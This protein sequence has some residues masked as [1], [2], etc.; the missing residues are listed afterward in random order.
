MAAYNA[1]LYILQSVQSVLAQTFEDFELL[2]INDG[3]TDRTLDILSGIAD[4]RLRILNNPTNLGVVGSRNRGMA[5]AVGRYVA[6][7]DADDFCLPTRFAKQKAFL[8]QHPET[9]IVGAEMSVLKRGEIG[10][11]PADRGRRSARAA[12][13][14]AY[15]QPRRSTFQ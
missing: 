8:D 11:Q 1:E 5:E 12:V 7:L 3:S 14:V 9:T 13:D 15:K 2:V 6:L 4:R 10:T